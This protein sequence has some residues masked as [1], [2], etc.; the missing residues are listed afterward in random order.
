MTVKEKRGRR[1]Y[2]AFKVISDKGVY[3]EDL[4]F[5]LRASSTKMGITTPKLIQFDEMKG[6]VRCSNLDK[7]V[8]IQLLHDVGRTIDNGFELET[9]R[10]SGTLKTLRNRYFT[11]CK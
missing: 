10:T 9:L 5:A 3:R 4:L 8:T 7:E 11:P 2:I 1:R 6:I